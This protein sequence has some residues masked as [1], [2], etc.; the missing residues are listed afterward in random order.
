[1]AALPERYRNEVLAPRVA[2]A[3]D[4]VLVA[5]TG[6]AAVGCLVMTGP[7]DGQREIKRLWTDPAHRGRG[8]A[9]GLLGAAL[10]Q[11]AD[12]GVHTVRLSVWEW[13]AAA[14]GLYERFGFVVAESWDGRDRLVCMTA[15]VPR[16]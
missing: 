8:V 16:T 6:D 3:G 10:T 9:A 4:S 7:A 11:A 12:S 15:P 2:F 13:R 1:V 14:I 5:A